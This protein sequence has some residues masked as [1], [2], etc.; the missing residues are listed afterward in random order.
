MLVGTSEGII[1]KAFDCNNQH[2]HQPSPQHCRP[3]T[4]LDSSD[5]PVPCSSH[6]AG[7]GHPMC[8][9]PAVALPLPLW[10]AL[11]LLWPCRLPPRPSWPLSYQPRMWRPLRASPSARGLCSLYSFG[12]RS[13]CSAQAC[14]YL[15]SAWL[16]LASPP[17]TGMRLS[18]LGIPFLRLS[19][20]H[21]IISL[22]V[23]HFCHRVQGWQCAGVGPIGYVRVWDLSGV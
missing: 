15:F 9:D 6:Y 23:R 16:P 10:C 5:V 20:K 2:Q 12:T 13:A 21:V 17:Y 7:I 18:V 3:S 4:A 8:P 11:T 19:K 14:A 1:Y 22:Q